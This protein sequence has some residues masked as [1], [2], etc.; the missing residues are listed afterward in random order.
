MT[1]DEVYGHLRICARHRK[2]TRSAT[3]WPSPPIAPLP[4]RDQAGHRPGHPN[5]GRPVLEPLQAPAPTP[6]YTA[7]TPGPGLL[8]TPARLAG[9]SHCYA[10]RAI[11][12]ETRRNQ[13]PTRGP[14]SGG[15]PP[16]RRSWSAQRPWTALRAFGGVWSTRSRSLT[17]AKTLSLRGSLACSLS[18][19]P[20]GRHGPIQPEIDGRAVARSRG[21]AIVDQGLGRDA[22]QPAAPGGSHVQTDTRSSAF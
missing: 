20:V 16:R 5:G 3:Y 21:H 15:I 4:G 11:D 9:P 2:N 17:V 18:K 6:R 8:S 12:H 10:P 14:R 22:S 13:S 19:A 7:S 1:R